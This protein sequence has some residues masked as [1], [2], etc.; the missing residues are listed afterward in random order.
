MSDQEISDEELAEISLRP[1]IRHGGELCIPVTEWEWAST[2]A[3][4]HSARERLVAVEAWRGL[5]SGHMLGHV[6]IYGSDCRRCAQLCAQIVHPEPGAGEE[7][8]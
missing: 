5:A 4:L 6:G 8:G 3:S 7:E 1:R 2:V